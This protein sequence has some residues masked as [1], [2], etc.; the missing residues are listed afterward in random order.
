MSNDE[1]QIGTQAELDQYLAAYQKAAE[2]F[3]I[4][5]TGADVGLNLRQEADSQGEV[6]RIL[7][8]GT[9]VTLLSDDGEWSQVSVNGLTGYVMSQY[10][11]PV[12][13][14]GNTFDPVEAGYEPMDEEDYSGWDDAG[15]LD[16]EDL[17]DGP[18]ENTD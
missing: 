13:D 16:D 18:L 11:R 5:N 9:I 7:D 1:V 10:L 14:S 4:V 6:L 15:Q 3:A 2:V 8:N 12:E 17:A